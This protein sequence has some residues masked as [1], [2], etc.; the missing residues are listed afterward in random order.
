[1]SQTK[2][3]VCNA[4]DQGSIAGPGR[5]PEERHGYPLQCFCLEKSMDRGAWWATVQGVPKSWTQLSRQHFHFT[6]IK[7]SGRVKVLDY[8]VWVLASILCKFGKV[9]PFLQH[10]PLSLW[11]PLESRLPSAPGPAQPLHMLQNNP[12]SCLL[13]AILLRAAAD[14][15]LSANLVFMWILNSRAIFSP[16]R[17]NQAQST[18][19]ASRVRLAVFRAHFLSWI[20]SLNTW[21]DWSP[22][23]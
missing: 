18:S 10:S 15:T 16:F 13:Q 1:M 3:S 4:G 22:R 12:P 2:E 7:R 11:P 14:I 9:P 19:T 23:D 21:K 8:E 5:S 20:P 6:F 17:W